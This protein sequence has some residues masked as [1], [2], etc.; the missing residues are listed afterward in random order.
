MT[1]TGHG[2]SL[3]YWRAIVGI[4]IVVLRLVLELTP[5]HVALMFVETRYPASSHV[6]G[7]F[8][9]LC[10]FSFRATFPLPRANH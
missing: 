5:W 10:P 2:N 1:K 3:A 4:F 6:G 7:R 8:L 9:D